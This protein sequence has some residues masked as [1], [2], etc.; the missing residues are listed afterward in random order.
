[1]GAR[2]VI[3]RG[4]LDYTRADGATLRGKYTGTFVRVPG[5]FMAG[6]VAGGPSFVVLTTDI[7]YENGSGGLAGVT[8]TAHFVALATSPMPGATFSYTV[9]GSLKFPNRP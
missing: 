8:G 9:A 3:L 5:S 4:E 7:K 1:V 6:P 2:G